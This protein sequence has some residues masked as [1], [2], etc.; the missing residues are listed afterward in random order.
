M[1]VLLELGRISFAQEARIHVSLRLVMV[2]QEPL[3]AITCVI[4]TAEGNEVVRSV[5]NEHGEIIMDI[6]VGGYV[7]DVQGFLPDGTAIQPDPLYDTVGGLPLFV[8]NESPVIVIMVDDY[9]I[10]SFV[11]PQGISTGSQERHHIINLPVDPIPLGTIEIGS[12]QA[13][14]TPPTPTEQQNVAL[15]TVLPLASPVVALTPVSDAESAAAGI[16]VFLV[17]AAVIVVIVIV[18]RRVIARKH[19]A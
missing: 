6:A 17:V 5:T 14:A 18:A 19:G 3:R 15:A 12:P 8:R 11:P 16:G 7:L 2:N 9:G 1:F 10:M 13:S 4:R